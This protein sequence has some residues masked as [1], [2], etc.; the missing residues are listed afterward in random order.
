MKQVGSVEELKQPSGFLDWWRSEVIGTVRHR[1]VVEKIC[2]DSGWSAHF[3][4]MV[5]MSA[6]IAVLGLLLSSPAVVIGAMLL[7]PLMGPIIG[8]GFGLAT[9]DSR[10]LKRAGATVAVGTVLA[11]GFC[12]LVT[13]LSP[14]QTVT[15]EIAAR[16]RPNLFDLLVALFS[17]LAATYAMI[18]G[19]HGAIVGVAIATALMPPLAVMGFGLATSNWTVLAGSTLLYFTNLMTIGVSAAGLARLYGFGHTLSP[20]QTGLQATVIVMI[21]IALA[22]PLGLS[23]KRIAWEALASRQARETISAYFGPVARLSRLEVD[24]KAD[25]L[26]VEATVFTPRYRREAESEIQKI[27]SATVKRPVEIS[28]EQFRI[29]GEEGEAEVAQIAAAKGSTAEAGASRIAARLALVAGVEP[30][31]VLVDAQR[32]RA[33]VRAQA[34]PM[35]GIETYQ[36]LEARVAAAEPRWQV[37]LIPPAAELPTIAFEGDEPDAAGARGL[38][39]AVW[40]AR[41]LGLALGV[42]GN[43][44]RAA[45]VEEAIEGQGIATRRVSGRGDAVRLT[46]LAPELPDGTN[47]PAPAR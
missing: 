29:G 8:L 36:T 9:F 18:R 43:A 33:V 2:E 19:R 32:R 23:L 4:F 38:A 28:I 24:Y 37:T 12:A 47:G 26:K 40:G 27:F 17:G 16:T 15:G 25:P 41:R 31:Q 34:L 3:A 10:E 39:S 30:E 21:I 14:L 42:S 20:R 7:S 44:R 46:W 5:I 35:A 11:V 1:E 22:V 13:L 6:G 45:V